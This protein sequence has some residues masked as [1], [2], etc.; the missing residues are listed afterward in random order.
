MQERPILFSM[1][2]LT[3]TYFISDVELGFVFDEKSDHV[4]MPSMGS[5]DKCRLS[6]LNEQWSNRGQVGS[7]D[8]SEMSRCVQARPILVSM[9]NL[10]TTYVILDV[11][12][13]FVF[14]E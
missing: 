8:W 11:E 5:P 7:F 13:G 4:G 14:D 6:G 12:L 10:T 2:N 3:T 9:S 1:S